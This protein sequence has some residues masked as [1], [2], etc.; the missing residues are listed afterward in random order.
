M[1]SISWWFIEHWCCQPS[2]RYRTQRGVSSDSFYRIFIG[3]HYPP[4]LILNLQKRIY[5]EFL[6][7]YSFLD[8]TISPPSICNSNL[9]TSEYLCWISLHMIMHTKYW[10]KGSTFWLMC[11]SARAAV[12]KPHKLQDDIILTNYL[13]SNLSS[14]DQ[15]L[16]YW[17][18]VYQH[19]NFEGDT[20]YLIAV[21]LPWR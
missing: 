1:F 21:W 10:A 9:T 2:I 14:K 8:K 6:N 12:T 20:V 17:G 13:R 5:T 16:K 7:F 3:L 18:S 15:I 4:H 11:Y 19:T